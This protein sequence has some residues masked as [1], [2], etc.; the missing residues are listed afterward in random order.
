MKP[1]ILLDRDGVLNRVVVDPEHGTIDSP[2]HPSQVELITG[3]PEALARLTQAGYALAIV[4]NQPSAAKGKTTRKNLED[5]HQA[6]LAAAQSQG[7]VIQSSHICFHRSE[8]QCACRKPKTGLL[9]AAIEAH[10]GPAYLKEIFATGENHLLR[11]SGLLESGVAKITT[12]KD[13]ESCVKTGSLLSRHPSPETTLWMIGDGITDIQAGASLG[14]STAFLGPQ[15]CDA[16]KIFEEMGLKP[17]FWGKDLLEFVGFLG[18]KGG[19]L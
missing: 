8:D 4:T 6:V 1:L 5:T 12:A 16:C 3:V 11:A 14:I 2:L 9:E 10:G 18:G 17:S 19:G 13:G 15:K 7:G